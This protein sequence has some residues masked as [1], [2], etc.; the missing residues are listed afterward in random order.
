[1]PSVQSVQ[2]MRHL[3]GAKMRADEAQAQQRK[4]RGRRHS[5]SDD[6]SPASQV[7]SDPLQNGA[8]FLMGAAK[9]R[10]AQ[11]CACP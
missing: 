4:Q 8:R 1:M 6:A 5:A 9:L 11:V 7:H 3:Q 2:Q 10:A